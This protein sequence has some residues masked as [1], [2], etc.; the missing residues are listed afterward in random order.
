ME[1]GVLAERAASLPEHEAELEAAE[2]A[3]A[4]RGVSVAQGEAAL[5]ARLAEAKERLGAVEAREGEL[6]EAE[7]VS[8]AGSTGS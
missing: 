8:W 6:A 7:K 2:R 4:Q 5:D 3:L 1:R